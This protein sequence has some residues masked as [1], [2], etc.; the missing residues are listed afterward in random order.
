MGTADAPLGTIWVN[1][2]EKNFKAYHKQMALIELDHI[3]SSSQQS[4]VQIKTN[5]ALFGLNALMKDDTLRPILDRTASIFSA[6]DINYN[7]RLL[8][9]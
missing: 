5:F 8:T 7:S 1:D 2:L 3:S 6:V 9:Q 4:G